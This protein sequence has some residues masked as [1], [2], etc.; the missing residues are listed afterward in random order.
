MKLLERVIKSQN[1]TISNTSD[2]VRVCFE[3]LAKMHVKEQK[4]N[5]KLLK[6]NHKLLKM[7]RCLRIKLR[8]KI[9]SQEHI[10]I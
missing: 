8:L 3:I 5:K 4:R 2:E 1:Q 6:E 9:L 10:L 7:V